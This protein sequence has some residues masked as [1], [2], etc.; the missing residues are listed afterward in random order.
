MVKMVIDMRVYCDLCGRF[1]D[2]EAT[3]ECEVGG[4]PNEFF[5]CAEVVAGRLDK[6]GWTEKLLAMFCPECS[7]SLPS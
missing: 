2:H 3:K 5:R 7:R 4:D 6:A 1:G